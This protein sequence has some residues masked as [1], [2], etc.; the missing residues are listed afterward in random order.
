MLF[1]RIEINENK[2]EKVRNK[3]TTEVNSSIILEAALLVTCNDVITNKQKPK[4]LANVGKMCC[5]V[6]LAI[7]KK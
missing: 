1:V 5:E 3:A 2:H 6:L 4:R 7:S